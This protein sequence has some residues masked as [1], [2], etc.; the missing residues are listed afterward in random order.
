MGKVTDF[1]TEGRTRQLDRRTNEMSPR[2]HCKESLTK[3]SGA[4]L[5]S[6]IKFL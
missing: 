3:Q 1:V 4:S 6:V 5:I 2:F